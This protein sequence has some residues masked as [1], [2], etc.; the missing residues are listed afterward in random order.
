MFLGMAC[1]G[2]RR[3]PRF[4]AWGVQEGAA[5]YGWFKSESGAIAYSGHHLSTR[6]C[7]AKSFRCPWKRSY[8]CSTLTMS[9]HCDSVAGDAPSRVVID[10]EGVHRVQRI[11]VTDRKGRM[12]TSAAAVVVL[13]IAEQASSRGT[14]RQPS[15][16]LRLQQEWLADEASSLQIELTGLQVTRLSTS[17]LSWTHVFA[18]RRVHLFKAVGYQELKFNSLL[19]PTIRTEEHLNREHCHSISTA[20]DW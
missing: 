7:P 16:K 14:L 12:Q 11:P 20:E 5:P 6:V 10:A 4:Q 2:F 3:L 18:P 15:P 8:T 9:V 1:C 13:P 19:T 17:Y